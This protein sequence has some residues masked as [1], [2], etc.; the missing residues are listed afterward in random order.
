MRSA[1][2]AATPLPDP[3]KLKIAGATCRICTGTVRNAAVPWPGGSPV[4]GNASVAGPVAVPAG[5]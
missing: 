2:A 1:D 5:M 3:F 4:N